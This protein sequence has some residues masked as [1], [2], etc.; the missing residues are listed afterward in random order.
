MNDESIALIVILLNMKHI[1]FMNDESISINCY[2]IK[3]ETHN[4]YE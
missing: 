1:I 4:L 2:T 3:H